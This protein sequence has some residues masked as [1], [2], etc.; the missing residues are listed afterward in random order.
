MKKLLLFLSVFGMGIIHAQNYIVEGNSIKMERIIENTNLDVES[1]N[2]ILITYLSKIYNDLNTTLKSNTTRNIVV[3]GIYPSGMR[4]AMGQWTADL[5][6]QISIALKEGRV[7]AE[8]SISKVH[9]HSSQASKDCWITDLY[10]INPKATGMSMNMT[11]K[12][13]EELVSIAI[14]L[15]NNTLDEIEN[16]LKNHKEEEDW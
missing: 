1:E 9:Q 3:K 12:N 6:H 5:H 7:K 11:K 16:A 4:Y 15:M 2:D 10:P 8:V 13:S 14:A